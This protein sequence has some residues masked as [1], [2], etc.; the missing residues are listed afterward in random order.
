MSQAFLVLDVI[1]IRFFLIDLLSIYEYKD[2]SIKLLAINYF[3]LLYTTLP[4]QLHQRKSFFSHEVM[5][6]KLVK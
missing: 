1:L 2:K 3:I 4:I 6:T 5:K